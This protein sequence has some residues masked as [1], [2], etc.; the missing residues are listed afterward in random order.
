MNI[1]L[2]A[3][4]LLREFDVSLQRIKNKLDVLGDVEYELKSINVEEIDYGGEGCYLGGRIEAL[5]KLK[6]IVIFGD[7]NERE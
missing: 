6:E 4:L 5:E 1:Q 2:K 3:N 7:K